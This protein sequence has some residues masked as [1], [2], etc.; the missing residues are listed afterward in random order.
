[1]QA[2][3]RLKAARLHAGL[4]ETQIAE[5]V[6]LPE[7]WYFDLEG[8]PDELFSNLSLAHLQLVADAVH[9]SPRELL[10]DTKDAGEHVSFEELTRQLLA[11]RESSG[12]S[13]AAL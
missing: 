1:M 10:T 4:S 9:V 6:G 13:V 7:A 12:L 8:F 11:Y 5:Q 3:Q 2:C